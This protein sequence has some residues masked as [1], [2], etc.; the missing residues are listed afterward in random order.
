[1]SLRTLLLVFG[2]QLDDAVPDRL[3][4]D[5]EH[6]AIWMAEATEEIEYVPSHKR[7]IAAFLTAMRHYR[8]R[9]RDEGWTVHYHELR[10]DAVE[11]RATSFREFLIEDLDRL[12]PERI[13]A[14]LPGDWRVRTLLKELSAER[15][16]SGGAA[17]EL[18]EDEHF[19]C[20]L[21]DF[22]EWADGRKRF[23]LEDFYRHMRKRDGVLMEGGDPVGGEWNFDSDNRKS[24]G[25][26]GPGDLP[27]IPRF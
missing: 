24:F 4:L 22:R 9:R 2:D 10:P 13:V 23:L 8:D 6:D 27:E 15:E 14:V 17:I 5:P 20:R 19:L 7:R 25:R 16:P 21:E 11:D 1:M 18:V 12:A 26:D 3:E